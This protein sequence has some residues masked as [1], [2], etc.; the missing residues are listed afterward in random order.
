MA[1]VRPAASDFLRWA[2]LVAL[3]G[4]AAWASTVPFAVTPPQ[5]PVGALADRTVRAPFAINLVDEEATAERRD[6]A[7][8]ATPPV[9]VW[10]PEVPQVLKQSIQDALAPL[11]DILSAPREPAPPV[12]RGQRAA[13]PPPLLTREAVAPVERALGV[14]LPDDALEELQDADALLRLLRALS[15]VIDDAYAVPLTANY[16]R[17]ERAARGSNSLV[18]LRSARDGA[19]QRRVVVEALRSV[20]SL[21]VSLAERPST[22]LEHLPPALGRLVVAVVSLKVLPNADLDDALTAERREASAS[23]VLPVSVTVPAGAVI[24]AE[25]QPVLRDAHL[26]LRHLGSNG[27]TRASWPSLAGRA[28]LVLLLMLLPFWQAGADGVRLSLRTGSF[29]FLVT[30]LALVIGAFGGWLVLVAGLRA[31]YPGLAEA[32]LV[33]LFPFAAP[34]IYAQLVVGR[35][36]GNAVALAVLAAIIGLVWRS[37]LAIMAYAFAAGVLGARFAARCNRRQ[38]VLRAGLLC[39]LALAC[40]AP[41]I[42]LGVGDPLDL[43]LGLLVGAGLGSGV[44]AAFTVLAL[45]PILEWAFNQTSTIRLV[46]LMNY[47]HPLL[48]RLIETAPGTFQH[49]VNVGI[50]ADAAARAVHADSLLVRVGA[51]YHDVGKTN[52]P[53]CFVEN[54]HGTSEHDHLP[55]DESAR[56]IIAHVP[57]GEALLASHGLKTQLGAFVREHHGTTTAAYFVHKAEQQGLDVNLDDYRYPGPRPQSRETGILMI[58]DQ[59]EATARTL[60][61]PDGDAF[62]A[63]A[64]ATIDRNREERQFDDCPLTMQ[65]LAQVREA[66]AAALEGIYH[67]RI[68][69]PEAPPR[70][71]AG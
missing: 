18:V 19:E 59:V 56:L 3:A 10:R 49:S 12:R 60:D 11:L 58:A 37:D 71:Q 24:V 70:P 63:L 69:Y 55:P 14:L 17:I 9:I 46:E 33:Y 57:E 45:A 67:Q 65:D 26:V 1:R 53:Q 66:I 35:D 50:L 23:A 64:Q 20:E 61:E 4:A 34:A 22:R 68:K 5:Y 52:R 15:G 21:R 32:P 44:L 16:E 30:M 6:A 31:S 54:Q 28:V 40:A 27:G 13:P 2:T 51:L 25:G 41:G 29:W 47:Q 38:C 36:T 42:A 48:R 7:R 8:L 62:R 39:G 43:E